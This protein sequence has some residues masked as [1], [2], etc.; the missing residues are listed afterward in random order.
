MSEQGSRLR[1]WRERIGAPLKE[2]AS[3]IPAEVVVRKPANPANPPIPSSEF[4]DSAVR[5]PTTEY[6]NPPEIVKD[7]AYWQSRCWSDGCEREPLPEQSQRWRG[8]YCAD[9]ERALE[10]ASAE[11]A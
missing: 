7:A 8:R 2:S 10:I 4:A 9:C 5:K 3:E 6:A 1:S 11:G